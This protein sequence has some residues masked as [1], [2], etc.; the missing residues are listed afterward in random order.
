MNHYYRLVFNHTFMV[1]QAVAEFAA[2]RGKSKSD[3]KGNTNALAFLPKLKK[4][5]L[6]ITLSQIF[7][8]PTIVSALPAGADVQF[9]QANI[10]TNGNNL[11]I[12]QGSKQLIANWQSFGIASN[13]SVNLIQ[14]NQGMALF[15]V[16]G[17]EA[18]QIYGSLNVTG[19]LFLVNPNGVLFGQG[20]MVDVGSLVATSMNISNVDFLNGRYQF[21]ADGKTGSV[22]N[23]GVIKAAE[24]GYI[25][26]L[27]NEVKNNGSLTANNGSVVLGSA[28]SAVLDFYGN[29]LVKATLSG[30]ALSALVEQ[31][32]T[33]QTDAGAVQLA[34]NSRSSAINVSGLVQANTLVERNG[35][36]RL[37]GGDNAKV[38]VN[39][40]LSASGNQAS[41][42]GGYIEVTGEQVALLQDAK[43]DAAGHAG[44]GTVLVGGDYLG[45]N[46]EVYN[47]R[48][49]FIA[50]GASIDVSAN[51]NGDGGKAIVWSN[52][53]T[54]YYG[55]ILAKGGEEGGNG[56]FAEVSGKQ[57]LDF[58]GTADLSASNGKGG[59]LLLDPL[60]IILTTV[61]TNTTGFT[62]PA[63]LTQAFSD[64]AGLDSTFR[65]NAGGSFA[66]IAG[67]STITLQ[68]TNNITVSSAFNVA[69]A[70][71][72]ANNSL[73]L[74]ANNNIAVNAAVTTSGSGSITMQADADNNGTGNLSIGA[75]ITSQTGGIS[76]S[77]ATITRSAG[78]VTATGATNENA[79]NISITSSGTTNLGAATITANGGAASAGNSGRNGGAITI[80]TGGYVG[81]GA[82]NASG[83][84]GNGLNTNGGNAGS[85]N[86]TSNNGIN[87]GTAATSASGGNAGTS[88]NGDGGNAGTISITNNGNGEITTGAITSRVGV[89]VGT[90]IGGAAGT[91]NVNNNA[92]GG[93]VSTGAINTAGNNNSN[94]NGGN[95]QLSTVTGNITTGA[96][97]SSGGTVRT[98]NAGKDAGM[99]TVNSGGSFTATTLTAN[100]SA[101]NGANQNGG[102]GGNITINANSGITTTAIAASG[103]TARAVNGDGGNAGN[104]NLANNN[105]G[106]ITV[107]TLTARTGVAVGT[108][109]G[110][111]AGTINVNNN[112]IGGN[113]ST[114]AISTQ[115]ATLGHGGNINLSGLGN[116]SINGTINSSGG[117]NLTGNTG[118]N[119]GNVIIDATG[120]LITGAITATGIAGIGANQNG[121]FGGVVTLNAGTDNTITH[122]NIDTRGGA[123]TGIGTGGNGGNI[124]VNSNSLLSANT[125]ITATVGTGG[126]S[127]GNINFAGT[128]DSSN[129]NRTLAINTT[130]A[131]TLNGPIGNTLALTS[132]TTNAGGTTAINGGSISTTGAQTY[133]NSVTL[134]ATTNLTTNNSAIAFGNS[135][136]A[137]GNVLTMSTGT[138][139]ITATNALNDFANVAIASANNVNL[140]DTNAIE[141]DASNVAG[142]YTLRTAGAVTQSGGITVGGAT[143]IN[144][145]TAN[146]IT[147]NNVSNNFNSVAITSG[148]DVSIVDANAIAVNASSVRTI[149]VQTLSGD[150]TLGGTITATG[151]GSGS[152]IRLAAAQNFINAGNFGLTPGAGSRWLVYSTDPTADT[153][154]VGLITA[155]NFKQY[156]TAFPDAP[157]GAGNGFV[158][159]IAPTITA[160]LVGTA[161]KTYDGN[162]VAPI[163]S[164]SLSQSGAIDGD[165]VNLSAITSATFN[166]RNAGIGKAITSNEISITTATND[167]KQVF[168]YT[169][170]SPTAIGNVGQINPRAIT[171][172]ATTDTKTYNGNNTSLVSPSV[173][174]GSIV[175]GDT[176]N[177]SQTFDNINAGIGKTL[178]ATGNVNDGNGGNNYAVTFA[179]NNSG[180]I[181]PASLTIT[182]N[183][184]QSKIFGAAD[185]FPFTFSIGGSGLF[186]G[187]TLLGTLNRTPG[188][189]IGAY[190][191]NQGTLDA[192][193]N[194][195]INFIGSS[196]EILSQGGS[197]STN[198]SPRDAAGFGGLLAMNDRPTQGVAILNVAA[199]AAGNETDVEY[200][201]DDCDA[202]QDSKLNIPN[203]SVI[204]N[205]G[206]KL[207]KGVNPNCL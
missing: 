36:I 1:W 72:S 121:G 196:F 151:T 107:T 35:V 37:E 163:D 57:F 148:R 9:G 197:E 48:T 204:F 106:D 77:G 33:I 124:N 95:I 155:S 144:A 186:G 102:D 205:F 62:P 187:D 20:A 25:V 86:I 42:K 103:N 92:I 125:T 19:S 90:G 129:L 110:G 54:R 202:N 130:G 201:T 191:I 96:L 164:L 70:T 178:S 154:G 76:L 97:N 142:N 79:G 91:I 64:D 109:I 189:A 99:I 21:N 156:N 6:C 133:G 27:G 89:A 10:Q 3:S 123:R 157:L 7:A 138:G 98:G 16:I 172:S 2:T 45:N 153:R 74:Q 136:N 181:N 170:A 39:G 82:I 84:N 52:S 18:S 87:R 192:G 83:S 23:Q 63:D 166:D 40:T 137:N 111:N 119:A 115:G 167:G 140:R 101:G 161:T 24:G 8:T 169:L 149:A 60:N 53:T 105:T 188:E 46:A 127:S 118:R 152:S 182:A 104:I 80:N 126:L 85:I 5:I 66:G 165:T 67:G 29:G 180:I 175:S 177:F 207:P 100:G 114:G 184:G 143:S 108:G 185:P 146:N 94:G 131:T 38:I 26:M 71:G 51:Q 73:V 56:G 195:T 159:T 59:N 58:A 132:L 147:L 162:T 88:G 4:L 203:T 135:I 139:N 13:E 32:G 61:D 117:T 81:T 128:I 31:S 69:T 65:V 176:G 15:R 200:A 198:G 183:S 193:A 160:N 22:V 112:A 116:I 75:N 120:N 150:L 44:G 158:Y 47:A 168:G 179:T 113:V 11:N 171:V 68:A 173:S 41:T 93:N 55:N 206:M 34:T 194:Y 199:P 122:A 145:G 134:G 78:N 30:D 49:S 14:P 43:L 141:L 12:T 190:A 28:Q 174:F 50:Q 17:S